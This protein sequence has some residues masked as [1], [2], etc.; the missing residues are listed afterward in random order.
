MGF[1]REFFDLVS[2]LK[3]HEIVYEYQQGLYFRNGR[4]VEKRSKRLK[5]EERKKI[6]AEERKLIKEL[7]YSAFLPFRR[8]WLELYERPGLHESPES[9]ESPKKPKQLSESYRLSRLTGLPLHKDR[10][11]KILRPGFYLHLPFL[12]EIVKD[13]K[14]E[15]ILN[16]GNITVPASDEGNDGGDKTILVSCNLRYELKDLYRAYTAVHD[17]EASLKDHTLSILAKYSRG[18]KWEEWKTPKVVEDLE[19]Q[20]LKGLREVVTEK[21]GLRIHKI[22]ITDNVSCTVHRL[23]HDGQPLSIISPKPEMV[24]ENTFI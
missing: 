22:Y 14:Q 21:W 11:S 10:F 15:R 19:I 16:L 13:S 2:K 6:S 3:F 18:K 20:V 17:Y 24:V 7:G 12:E 1:I 23:T 5:E 9:P 4:V 8:S